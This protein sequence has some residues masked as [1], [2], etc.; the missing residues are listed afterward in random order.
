MDFG[1]YFS[2]LPFQI[3]FL[4]YNGTDFSMFT[5]TKYFQK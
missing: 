4:V 1:A 5:S 3:P 2:P